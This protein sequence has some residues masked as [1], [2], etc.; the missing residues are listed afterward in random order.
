VSRF[1]VAYHGSESFHGVFTH[2][3]HF[4][5]CF[6]CQDMLH[7]AT[8]WLIRTLADSGLQRESMDL[9]LPTHA[10]LPSPM[11]LLNVQ[12]IGVIEWPEAQ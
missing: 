11:R 3:E 2:L 9:R 6:L 4:S 8:I 10:V 1:C 7:I 5:S 12:E